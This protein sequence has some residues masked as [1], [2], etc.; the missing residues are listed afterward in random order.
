MGKKFLTLDSLQSINEVISIIEAKQHGAK[1][2]KSTLAVLRL[3]EVLR[4]ATMLGELPTKKG[5]A[6]Q[7]SFE[8]M[9]LMSYH[10]EEIGTI[11]LTVGVKRTNKDKVQYGISALREGETLELPNNTPA[12]KNKK[13]KAPH[14]K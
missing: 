3:D 4:R 7:A 1:S 9:I 2:Y 12:D 14:K 5:N 6:N 11:K 13:R 10:C 8:R